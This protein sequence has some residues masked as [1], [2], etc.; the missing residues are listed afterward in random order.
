MPCVEACRKWML[1]WAT[2]GGTRSCKAAATFRH[3]RHGNHA[4]AQSIHNCCICAGAAPLLLPGSRCVFRMRVSAGRPSVAPRSPAKPQNPGRYEPCCAAPDH[5]LR[6]SSSS[7]WKVRAYKHACMHACMCE[8]KPL[9]D[10]FVWAW[11][12]TASSSKTHRPFIQTRDPCA[13]PQNINSWIAIVDSCS[14]CKSLD[15]LSLSECKF[16][17]GQGMATFARSLGAS[18]MKALDISTCML[19]DEFAGTRR[20]RLGGALR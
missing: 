5:M 18:E 2:L 11:G 14:K 16:K 20:R 8:A 4:G 15:K 10:Y 13:T 17:E 3:A 1:A 7:S 6:C 9:E 19:G 12:R